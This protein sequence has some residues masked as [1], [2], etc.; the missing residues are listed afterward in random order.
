MGS[1][2]AM[3]KRESS[4]FVSIHVVFSSLSHVDDLIYEVSFRLIW[5]RGTSQIR[6]V[7]RLVCRRARSLDA[8]AACAGGEVADRNPNPCAIRDIGASKKRNNLPIGTA[9]AVRI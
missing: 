3:A 6:Y 7:K 4:G 5:R 1:R 9:F 2:L 8:G